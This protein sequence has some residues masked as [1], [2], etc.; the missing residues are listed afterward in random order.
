MV[1]K[2]FKPG[3]ETH[4][5]IDPTHTQVY[6]RRGIEQFF[7]VHVKLYVL[8]N[9]VTFGGRPIESEEFLNRIYLYLNYDIDLIQIFN[10]A[11]GEV[12]SDKMSK[13]E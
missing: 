1:T 11:I 3:R 13:T 12:D 5:F 4:K 9:S 10:G 6:K 2:N 7:D 8:K